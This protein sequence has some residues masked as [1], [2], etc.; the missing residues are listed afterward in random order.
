MISRKITKVSSQVKPTDFDIQNSLE[1]KNK[2]SIMA[3]GINS[4]NGRFGI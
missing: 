3:L 4:N 2:N 1:S